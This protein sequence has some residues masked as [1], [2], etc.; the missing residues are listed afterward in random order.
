MTYCVTYLVDRFSK[1]C[2]HNIRTNGP[3]DY[4]SFRLLVFSDQ[5]CIRILGCPHIVGATVSDF[6]LPWDLLAEIDFLV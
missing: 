6:G 1:V 4:W 5:W 3:S 2:T